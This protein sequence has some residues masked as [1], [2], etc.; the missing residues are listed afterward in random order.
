LR[1]ATNEECET[2]EDGHDEMP[3]IDVEIPCVS[4]MDSEDNYIDHLD[5]GR[6]FDTRKRDDSNTPGMFSISSS[7]HSSPQKSVFYAEPMDELSDDELLDPETD[8]CRLE[9]TRIIG[10]DGDDTASIRVSE[11]INLAASR[12][13]ENDGVRSP[14]LDPWPSNATTA[15]SAP[16]TPT[17]LLPSLS[18]EARNDHVQVFHTPLK[19]NIHLSAGVDDQKNDMNSPRL[20]VNLIK[21]REQIAFTPPVSSECSPPR[22]VPSPDTKAADVIDETTQYLVHSAANVPLPISPTVTNETLETTTNWKIKANKRNDNLAMKYKNTSD[23][24]VTEAE[25]V[26]TTLRTVAKMTIYE[27]HSFQ[28]DVETDVSPI[29]ESRQ[30]E[31][32]KF[33]HTS[34]NTATPAH[35]LNDNNQ[36]FRSVG[37]NIDPLGP[38]ALS[39]LD[40]Y[41]TVA[42]EYTYDDESTTFSGEHV[43]PVCLCG[44]K[45]GDMLI[46]S[47]HCPHVYVVTDVSCCPRLLPYMA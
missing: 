23:P 1:S 31:T 9:G 27:T 22:S 32:A 25:V 30:D 16:G 14:Y 28:D 8:F 33:N 46:V 12:L 7:T 10:S 4:S 34:I 47:K 39:R 13:Q 24:V 43:C 37:A 2:A 3:V 11:S 15:R 20:T 26:P 40:S 17:P 44:Y 45:K 21:G 41:T 6:D 5:T 42:S 38:V 29:D 36:V 18:H 35:A 19:S